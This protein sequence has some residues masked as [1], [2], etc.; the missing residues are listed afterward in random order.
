MSGASD[1]SRSSPPRARCSPSAATRRQHRRGGPRR[2]G[3][4]A[5]RRAAV[6]HQARAVPRGLLGGRAQILEALSAVAAGPEAGQQMG[7][8]LRRAARG[9]RP[10]A[11]G[12]ARV[13]RRCG[14]GG[15]ARGAAHARGGV[16]AVPGAVRGRRRRRPR[17]SSR[18]ACSSTCCSRSTRPRTPARTPAWT[19]SCSASRTTSPSGAPRDAGGPAGD[20]GSASP[21]RPTAADGVVV[22]DK[23]AG[24]DQPRRRRPHAPPGGHPQGRPRRARSTRWRRASSCVGIG[25]ATRLLTYIV[26]ADK[27]YTATDPARASRRPPTTPRGRRWRVVDASGVTR[28]DVASGAAA[29]TGA[30]PAGAER[31]LAPSRSTV[32]ARTPGSGRARTSSSPRAR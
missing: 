15:R 31:G 18:R 26:G 1:A 16:P 19:R 28:D 2:G 7:E 12:H 22:V 21:A 13:H 20:R 4:A 3:V 29:L 17:C 14:R 27:E 9:P 24:L 8:R 6:R 23:P 30:D 5:L 25:R 10:A 32:S 11:A